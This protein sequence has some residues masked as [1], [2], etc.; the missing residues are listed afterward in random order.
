MTTAFSFSNVYIFIWL[1][2]V[3]VVAGRLS[4][5]STQAPEPEGSGSGGVWATS[6]FEACG[7]LVPRPGIKP[8]SPAVEGRF[9][10]T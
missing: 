1:L 7:I 5:C 8:M 3:S 9:L 6:C 2:Q 10:T 4:T